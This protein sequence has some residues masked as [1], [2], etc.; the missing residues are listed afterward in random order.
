MKG[1]QRLIREA[2]EQHTKKRSRST[3]GQGCDRM[4]TALQGMAAAAPQLEGEKVPFFEDEAFNLPF[5]L[6]TSQTPSKCSPG[7]GFLPLS[8]EGYVRY[9]P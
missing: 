1:K 7:R 4:L 6:A 5:T 9:M 8:K 3:A 2:C